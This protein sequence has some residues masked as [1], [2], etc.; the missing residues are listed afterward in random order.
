MPS[1]QGEGRRDSCRSPFGN[2]GRVKDPAASAVLRRPEGA[3]FAALR[4][5]EFRAYFVTGM[6][7]MMAD[8]IE[9]VISYWVIFEAF[10]S[11]ALAGFAVISHWLPHL[12]FGMAIGAL[13]DRHD[14]RR[15]LQVSQLVFIGVSVA[16]AVL[17]LTGTL[18]TWHAMIL[19]VAHGC[20]G[21]LRGPASQLI[22]HD[23]V[24]R[25]DLQSAVRLNST[26]RQLGSLFGP[27]VGGVLLV[28][29]GPAVGLAINCLA[30]LPMV[31]W[32][33]RTP[34]SGH[35]H[36]TAGPGQARFGLGDAM[37]TLREVAG[38]RAVVLMVALSGI[39]SLLVGNAFQAQM[40]EFASDFTVAR[41]EIT[42]SALLAASAAGAALGGVLIESSP[43]LRRPR[44]QSAIVLA[45]L[46][47][48]AIGV[49][50]VA[51]GYPV[52]LG[53]LFV[54]GFLSLAFGSIAQT[55]VQLEAPPDRRG[56]VVG[57]FGMSSQGLRV[58]SGVTVGIL[59]SFIGIHA[60]LGLSAAV[61][62]VLCLGLL[63]LA[64]RG[65]PAV[66][67]GSA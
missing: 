18:Q 37:R 48:L 5:A 45:A 65:T 23:I 13:A 9:H 11:P 56:R 30:Y 33:Q 47:S 62:L 28:I 52:A 10:R 4:H 38:N 20:A 59:G 24:G 34:F 46:W 57:L 66:P 1:P 2:N 61:L 16:W 50:A 67:R 35:L 25:G 32:L 8:N 31:V 55:L 6:L 42:Y 60:S 29:V 17:F 21:A 7:T 64:D 15:I 12:V 51:P 22:I 14:C 40:P 39:T 19:L 53:A 27:A 26:G 36:A 63:A 54:A 58:G 44:A 43:F 3:S 49:F 41:G